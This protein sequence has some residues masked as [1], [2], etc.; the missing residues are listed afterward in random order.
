M[1]LENEEFGPVFIQEPDD[2]IFALDSDEKKVMINCKARGNPAPIYR[3]CTLCLY[4]YLL[5][6]VVCKDTYNR[7]PRS[8]CVCSW[9]INRTE[10]DVEADFRYS[11]IDGNLIITNASEITDFG[12]YQCKAENSFG[13]ILSRDA[14]L[15]FA[16][17]YL[18]FPFSCS[19]CPTY[20]N[21]NL[22]H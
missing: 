1:S 14:L 13:T 7:V 12:R 18:I 2:A 16:C 17:E 9:F 10:V 11:L 20:S 21:G 22:V 19:Q 3:Y 8:H 6:D 15:R 5:L 4:L